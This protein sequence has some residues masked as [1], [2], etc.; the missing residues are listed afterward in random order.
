M[1]SEPRP[2]LLRTERLLL[3]PYL[4]T[5]VDDVFAYAQL[6]EWSQY[7]LPQIP[8]PYARADAES[9]V[10]SVLEAPW[11]RQANWA[12]VLNQ[13]VIGGL[14][15]S[16]EP[17]ER[18]AELGY[19]LAPNRWNQGFTT[20]AARAALDYAFYVTDLETVA[21][22][23]DARNVGSWRVMEKLGMRRVALDAGVREDRTGAM[24]D[25]VRYAIGRDAWLR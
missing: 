2:A 24:V 20:E 17:T 22:R 7:H 1:T 18:R 9:F 15:L 12:I 23:A 3:R 4:E 19:S 8:F 6:E 5:D 21:A 11:E 25:E 13:R 10:A 16:I 14:T